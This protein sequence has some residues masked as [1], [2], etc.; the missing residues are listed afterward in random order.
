MKTRKTV[1][2]ILV[3]IFFLS[4][5][6]TFAEE[7]NGLIEENGKMFYYINGIKQ[8]GFQ[9][10]EGNTYFFGRLDDHPM[11]TGTIQ[12]DGYTYHFDEDGIMVKGLY[13]ENNKT[14]YFD[15]NGR[16]RGGFQ[17]VGEDTYFF[18]RLDD[19]PMRTG[20][21][22]ID[23]NYYHFNEDGKM[24]KGFLTENN[25]T[26]YFNEEGKRVSGFQKIGEDTYFFGRL[27][28]NP[29]RTG[30]LNIDGKYYHFNEDGKMHKGFLTENNTTYYFDEEGKR[31]SGFQKI[32][33]DTYFFGRL[34]DNPMRTGLL[35]IDGYYYLFKDDG[36]MVTGW[37][38]E[39][40]GKAY[41]DNEGKK[42]F[43]V[44]IIDDQYYAF[45]KEG[46]QFTETTTEGNKKYYITETG[47]L[48][49]VVTTIPTYYNQKDSRWSNI[50]YGAKKFGPT[51]CA[52]TS[53]AMAFE[54]ILD[55]KILPTTIADYLYY[56]TK[57]YNRKAAGSS[58]LAI[59][60][61]S[62]Y[63][64]I[65]YEGINS[66][67]ELIERLKEGKIVF[68]AMGNGKF[69]TERWNHAII[70]VNLN[71]SGETYAYDP[72]E[73]SNNGWISPSRIWKEKSKDPDDKLGGAF[74]Y[75]LS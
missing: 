27:N 67:K 22:N 5:I 17:K 36:K 31:A 18:G 2:S 16:R 47:E 62:N 13:T 14:Y 28:D 10:I 4:A 56:K 37:N 30:T 20:T 60:K 52:P 32:G 12:I 34:D 59:I 58:G 49:K 71:D 51:G 21:L 75:A 55:K 46:Y 64:G 50:K 38:E 40:Q 19:N 41:Y 29:M 6:N 42:A 39:E 3:M 8:E 45:S 33:E 48:E 69:G 24:H 26:Y 11:R 7:K 44:K 54:S 73:K 68:A 63:F 23:G 74:L 25:K 61:A 65:K 43:G 57:E 9:I 70:V 35:Y 72:L 15:K 53:M 1:F 66:E